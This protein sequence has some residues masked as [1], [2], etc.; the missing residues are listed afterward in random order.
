MDAYVIPQQRLMDDEILQGYIRTALKVTKSDKS[1]AVHK[2]LY[3]VQY[4][5]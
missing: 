4:F 3:L 1:Q 5:V 2:L